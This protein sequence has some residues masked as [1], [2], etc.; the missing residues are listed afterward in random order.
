MLMVEEEPSMPAEFSNLL[1]L[2]ELEIGHRKK[3]LFTSDHV[4]IWVHGV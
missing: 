4:H 1:D 2:P 3:V